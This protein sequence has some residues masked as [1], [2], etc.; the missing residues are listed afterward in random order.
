MW[1]EQIHISI[2]LLKNLPFF[3]WNGTYTLSLYPVGYI[4]IAASMHSEH[5]LRNQ[6]LFLKVL[7]LDN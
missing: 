7:K 4:H 6:G 1:S 5:G 2:R 3:T